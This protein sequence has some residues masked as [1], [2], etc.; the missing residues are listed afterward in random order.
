MLIGLVLLTVGV[1]LLGYV[2]TARQ[3]SPVASRLTAGVPS[4]TE[5]ADSS[6]P[7]EAQ[8]MRVHSALGDAVL[9]ALPDEHGLTS[10]PLEVLPPRSDPKVVLAYE[11]EAE[12]EEGPHR[13]LVFW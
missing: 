13:R 6:D 7:G 5:L 9:A 1:A 8:V 2:V 10:A 4:A 11:D 12:E 3:P